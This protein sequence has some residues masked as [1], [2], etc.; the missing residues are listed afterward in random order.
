MKVHGLEH[1]VDLSTGLGGA[2]YSYELPLSD[3]I[4]LLELKDYSRWQLDVPLLV[5]R[6]GDRYRWWAGPRMLVAFYGT[7]LD[8][9]QP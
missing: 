6:H 3:Q 8:F 1:G 7:E 2:H 9:E 5:G 4:P